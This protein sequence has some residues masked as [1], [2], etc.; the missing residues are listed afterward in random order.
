MKRPHK[1]KGIVIELTAL[2]DVI[3]IML[4]WVMT[5]VQGQTEDI[6]TDADAKIASLEQKLEDVQA[7]ADQ[8]IEKAWKVAEN[9]NSTA[10]A[11]QQ[12]LY[13]YEQG[14]P[15]KLSLKYEGRAELY[16]SN[17]DNELG[18]IMVSSETEMADEIVEA[19]TQAGIDREDVVLCALI[20]DGEVALYRDVNAVKAAI[21][22]VTKT[23][24]GCYCTNINTAR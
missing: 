19:F 4:F 7:E 5:N 6:R 17:S 9:I 8:E 18:S 10:A 13:E 1:S 14:L 21:A 24:T 2:L 20:Y 16:I 11:N 15:V 12:A 23:Y 22:H 3:L